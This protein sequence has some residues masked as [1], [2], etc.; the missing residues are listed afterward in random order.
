MGNDRSP[1][2]STAAAFDLFGPR[3]RISVTH[4]EGRTGVALV[5]P[6][7]KVAEI[8]VLAEGRVVTHSTW[9]GPAEIAVGL[10]PTDAYLLAEALMAQALQID[11]DLEETQR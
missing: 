5:V 9:Q 8:N 11:P 1:R 6:V 7:G 2:Q 3:P 10:T 4:V